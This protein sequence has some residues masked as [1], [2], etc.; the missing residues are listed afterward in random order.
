MV[1]YFSILHI[2]LL[3]TTCTH[4][5]EALTSPLILQTPHDSPGL[6]RVF[7][8]TDFKKINPGARE[9]KKKPVTIQN[10]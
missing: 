1:S 6:C 4:N 5:I 7:N 2:L 10:P 3:K 8:H 9:L